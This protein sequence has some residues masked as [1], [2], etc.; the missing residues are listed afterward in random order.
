MPDF[1]R[2]TGFSK[3]L[4]AAG[5]DQNNP[6]FDVLLYGQAAALN[7]EMPASDLMARLIEEARAILNRP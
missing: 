2:M 4:I 5:E 6:D 3:P 7:R 1:P